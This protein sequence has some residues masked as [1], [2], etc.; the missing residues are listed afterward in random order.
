MRRLPLNQA[1]QLLRKFGVPDDEVLTIQAFGVKIFSKPYISV[2]IKKLSRWEVIDVVRTLSTE[3]AKQQGEEATDTMS[4]F[5]RGNR[6]SIAEHQERYKEECQRIFELQ[7]RILSS[8]EELSTDEDESEEEDSDIEEMGKNIESMLTN[9][10]TSHQIS[11]EKEEAERRELQ[12]M[13][14]GEESNQG[15]SKKRK[16]GDR[17]DDNDDALSLGSSTG[18]ILKIYRTYR[19]AE[20]KEYTRIETVRKPAVIEIYDRIRRTKDAA[21]IKQFASALDDQQKEEIR[22]EKR[23]IQEQLRRLKRNEEKTKFSSSMRHHLGINASTSE[24]STL[25]SSPTTTPTKPPKE[26]KPKKIK[27]EKEINVKLKCGACGGVGHMRTNRACP[28]FKGAD[29]IPPVQVAMTDEQLEEEE[30]HGLADDHLVKV[31]DGTKLV[32]KKAIIKHTDEVKSK[33][34]K[35]KIPKDALAMKRKRR[36]GTVDHCDYLQKPDYKSANRKRTD[37]MVTLSVILEEVLNDLRDLP[38]T[39]LFHYPVNSKHVADYYKIIKNPMDL[40]TMRQNI[41]EKRYTCRDE[42]LQH[43]N[44]MVENSKLYNGLNHQLTFTAQRM[45]ELAVKR[46]KEKEEKLMRIEKA[47]NPLLDDNHQVALSYIFENIVEKKLKL[48]PESWPFHKPVDKKLRNYFEIIENPVSLENIE[49]SIKQHKYQSREMFMEDIELIFRNSERFNGADSQFTKKAAEIVDAAREAILQYEEEIVGYE[50]MIREA[51]EKAL[52]DA[53]TD[54]VITGYSKDGGEDVFSTR[55]PS[56]TAFSYK[57]DADNDNDND[58]NVF[59]YFDDNSESNAI[60]HKE[61]N[62][63]VANDLE[64]SD[65]SDNEGMEIVATNEDDVID[66]SYDPSEF[67][68][69]LGGFSQAKTHSE[70][71]SEPQLEPQSPQFRQTSNVIQTAFVSQ[72]NEEHNDEDDDLWF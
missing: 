22:K 48:I 45:L 44:L 66:E 14:L 49:K 38:D 35:L 71:P 63:S 36:I 69:G 42:F 39:Q 64:I 68:A 40:Q 72:T 4:K 52:D 23:R 30:K 3:Q 2:Q 60:E 29:V 26:P 13:I 67:L 28:Q 33:S 18:R 50:Q 59:S 46:F 41:R 24:F 12:R 32:F 11:Q 54:S 55:P 34:L 21:Y 6:F 70:P 7:N 43:I 25:F 51:K 1:K 31:E 8:K 16:F 37:P 19:N 9:K 10:K 15:E 53:D 58:D 17:D 20:G 56:S 5:A 47:I 61:I 57:G 62:H 65:N 27:K